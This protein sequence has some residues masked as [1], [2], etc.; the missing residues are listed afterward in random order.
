MFET[1]K[2]YSMEIPQI[3]NRREA[4]LQREKWGWKGQLQR[5]PAMEREQRGKGRQS[6]ASPR[7]S[8]KALLKKGLERQEKIKGS[9]F[10]KSQGP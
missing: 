8:E 4:E 3:Y 1:V 10:A 9:R 6:E 2:F 5:G 7:T